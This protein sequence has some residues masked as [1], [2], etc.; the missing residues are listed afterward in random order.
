M[1]C[2]WRTVPVLLLVKVALAGTPA[3][4]MAQDAGDEEH[5]QAPSVFQVN[6]WAN[7]L[8]ASFLQDETDDN[9]SWGVELESQ[10]NLGSYQVK[11]I[12]Y[13]EVNQYERAVPGQPP[14]NPDPIPGAADGIGDLLSGFWI[15]K[16]GPHH[17]GH[18]FAPGFALQFPTASDD[19]LGSG[20]L[21]LGPSVDYELDAG[22]LFLGA[23]ALQIWSVAGDADRKDV[24]MLMIKPFVYYSLTEKW[25]LTYVPYGITVYWN[26][27]PGEKVYLPLGGGAQ[28]RLQLGSVDM[29]VGAQLFRNVIRPSKGTVWDLRFLVELAF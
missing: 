24:S 4:A 14:G 5:E 13:F 21:S 19:T 16:R 17:G 27:D 9:Q 29:N 28:R 18:H 6:R 25:D 8:F 26:K 3:G 10:L 20:K 23:I 15:S 7:W 1:V 11:N 22:R 2:S 12:S